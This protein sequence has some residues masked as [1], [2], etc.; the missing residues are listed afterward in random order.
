LK[1]NPFRRDVATIDLSDPAAHKA[2]DM[3]ANETGEKMRDGEDLESIRDESLKNQ[4]VAM[5]DCLDP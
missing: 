4:T 5:S 1:A 2:A 3:L